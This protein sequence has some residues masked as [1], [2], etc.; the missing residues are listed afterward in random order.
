L[1]L[2]VRRFS[3]APEGI[4]VAVRWYVRYG[5]SYVDVEE[6]LGER[7]GERWKEPASA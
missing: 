3:F 6:L 5:L 7:G 2:G 1:W 4:S